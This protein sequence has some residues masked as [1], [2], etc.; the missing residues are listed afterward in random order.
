M[1]ETDL[2]GGTRRPRGGGPDQRRHRPGCECVDG[3]MGCVKEILKRYR[4]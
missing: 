2:E 1:T 4:S 3:I